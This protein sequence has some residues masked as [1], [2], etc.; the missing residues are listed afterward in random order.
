M[1]YRALA[2]VMGALFAGELQ[3]EGRKQ[4]KFWRRGFSLP[5]QVRHASPV[6]AAPPER[7]EPPVETDDVRIGKLSDF[8][9][10]QKR[11]ALFREALRNTLPSPF[12]RGMGVSG[13]PAERALEV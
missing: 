4:G 3:A 2:I 1:R 12:S 6:H 8:L 9:R 13:C 11:H 7:R 10:C 5:G